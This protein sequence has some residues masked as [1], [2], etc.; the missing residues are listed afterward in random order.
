MKKFKKGDRV[1]MY[2]NEMTG[3]IMWCEEDQKVAKVQRDSGAWVWAS[4]DRLEL[5]EEEE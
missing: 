5:I 4:Y 3:I 1:S 2:E